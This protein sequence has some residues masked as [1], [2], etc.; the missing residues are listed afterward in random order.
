MA[1]NK[2][3]VAA[4]DHLI[5]NLGRCINWTRWFDSSCNHDMPVIGLYWDCIP[6]EIRGTLHLVKLT[7]SN[8]NRMK[9]MMSRNVNQSF[10]DCADFF[11][12]DPPYWDEEQEIKCT[13]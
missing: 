8:E 2:K 6:L 12:K 10:I 7:T 1:F 9:F 4:F 11:Y 13:T 5:G 3:D